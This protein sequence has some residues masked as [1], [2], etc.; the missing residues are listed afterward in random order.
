MKGVKDKDL[1][2]WFTRFS[3]HPA[4][5]V[6]IW[7]PLMLNIFTF[8]KKLTFY[9]IYKLLT[10]LCFKF[11]FFWRVFLRRW[12]VHLIIS[13]FSLVLPFHT[14]AHLGLIKGQRSSCPLQ[15]T[16]NSFLYPVT[17]QACVH[18][19]KLSSLP[20]LIS[21]SFGSHLSIMRKK[22]QCY[23]LWSTH[24]EKALSI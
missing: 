3:R 6:L 13:V 14:C 20:R 7:N 8:T 10:Y 4:P 16:C 9:Y 17:Q 1:F 11:C 2:G 15:H 24:I 21:N 23:H 18:E 22:E 19:N 5:P 12:R